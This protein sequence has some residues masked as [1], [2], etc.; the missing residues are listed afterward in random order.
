LKGLAEVPKADAEYR[1]E[2]RRFFDAE[3]GEALLGRLAL[4]DPE[5]SNILHPNDH[6]R[7]IRALEVFRQTGMTVSGLRNEHR[8]TGDNYRCLKIGIRVEREELYSRINSRVESMMAEG[9]EDEVRGLLNVGYGRDLKSMRSIG[10]R[11][12]CSY[13]ARE[14]TMEEAVT[15]IQRNTRHYGKRQETWLKT[16]PEIIWVEYPKSFDIIQ[17]HVHAFFD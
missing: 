1:D 10:Y 8:F 2:L 13:F 12:L 9:F 6:V 17:N 14:C 11:E 15:L 16:D 5:T 7:I 3:G 4:V